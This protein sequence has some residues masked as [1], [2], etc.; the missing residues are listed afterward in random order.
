MITTTKTASQKT[1]AKGVKTPPLAPTH[2]HNPNHKSS[3]SMRMKSTSLTLAAAAVL[4]ALPLANAQNVTATTDPV[5]FVTIDFQASTDVLFSP[6]LTTAPAFQ[7][8]VSSTVN[9]T[10]SVSPSP[11]WTTN[12]FAAANEAAFYAVATSGSQAGVIF[13]IVS[14][15][16][17]SITFS[18]SSGITPVGFTAGTPIKIVQYNTLGS[19]FPASSANASFVPSS[20]AFVRNTQILFPNVT[21]TGTNRSADQTF[22]FLNGAW[23]KVGASASTSYDNQPIA[24]DSYIIVRNSAT[25]PTGLKLTV[26]GSVNTA[27]TSI[28]IDR[29]TTG[30]NDNYVSSARPLDQTLDQTGIYESGSFVASASAFV[31][32]DE[33]LVFSNS[34]SG[35][36][37]SASATYY[38]LSGAGWRKV[39]SSSAAGSD[40]IP[41][42]SALVIRKNTAASNTTQ[43]WTNTITIQ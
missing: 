16:A 8:S 18:N 24:P 2:F 9:L 10:V 39:G 13:D 27:P 37:K 28:Q 14:N 1:P 22:Y 43:F 33:L 36:N 3:N 12:Q 21:A 35:I 31:R 42:G 4:A 23:R 30:K 7:G 15:T 34:A 11:N 6:P 40:V 29:L 38:Y 25:A 19:T 41:A 32:Q 5:G 20:S 17:D 26:T